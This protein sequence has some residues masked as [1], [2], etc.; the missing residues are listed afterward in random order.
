MNVGAAVC[1]MPAD[2]ALAGTIRVLRKKSSFRSF[3]A[4]FS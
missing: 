3:P 1:G 2:A 4:G